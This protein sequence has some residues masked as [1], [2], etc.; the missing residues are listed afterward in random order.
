VAVVRRF[1]AVG[2]LYVL[3]ALL[4]VPVLE[5]LRFVEAGSTEPAVHSLALLDDPHESGMRARD[6]DL[7]S[8]AASIEVDSE[9]IPPVWRQLWFLSLMMLCLGVIAFLW[10]RTVKR[11]HNIVRINATLSGAN[12]QLRQR[13]EEIAKANLALSHEL[14][15][16]TRTEGA[17][18]QSDARLRALHSEITTA[19]AELEQGFQQVLSTADLVASAS[20]HISETSQMVAGGAAAQAASLEEISSS[21]QVMTAMTAQNAEHARQ[22]HGLAGATEVCTGKG[23]EDANR[24]WKA[25]AEIKSSSDQT[26]KI[27]KTINEIAFQTN[28]LALNAAIEAARAGDAGKGFGVVAEEV[29]SLAMRA[30]AAARDTAK[31]LA[32]AGASADHAVTVNKEVLSSLADISEHVKR[33]RETLDQV[34]TASEYQNQGV[35]QISAGLDD[36]NKITQQNAAAAEESASSAQEVTDTADRLRDLVSRFRAT[37]TELARAGRSGVE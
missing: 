30:G 31:M 2:G 32:E 5:C 25:M 18:R 10:A 13:A 36:S 20:K 23:V 16:R 28:L 33:M 9:A 22:G 8:D 4:G 35:V 37:L 15:E 12:Q 1:A 21:L 26:E 3:V 19:V 11:D 17:L 27:V 6:R 7:D 24:L 14:Q 29:R 34:A